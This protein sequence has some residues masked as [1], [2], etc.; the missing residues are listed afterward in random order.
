MDPQLQ[1]IRLSVVLVTVVL[2]LTGLSV[3]AVWMRLGTPVRRRLYESAVICAI[4]A[5]VAVI[6]SFAFPS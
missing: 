1:L 5:V 3:S 4:A 2:I 6:A